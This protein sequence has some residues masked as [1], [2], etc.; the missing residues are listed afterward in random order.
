MPSVPQTFDKNHQE[1]LRSSMPPDTDSMLIKTITAPSAR[2]PNNTKESQPNQTVMPS[3]TM[4]PEK[5]FMGFPIPDPSSAVRI[6]CPVKEDNVPG[7]GFIILAKLDNQLSY[8]SKIYLLDLIKGIKVLLLDEYNLTD[9]WQG[10]YAVSPDRKW[11]AY[12]V[13]L[14][15][16]QNDK[17]NL[18]S[19]VDQEIISLQWDNSWG[20][21][22][23]WLDKEQLIL[24]PTP[25]KI[26]E[27]GSIILM[28]PFVGE[29]KKVA[30][31]F[32]NGIN[33]NVQLIPLAYYNPALTRV[34][35]ISGQYFFLENL[36][37]QQNIWQ[38]SGANFTVKP[39]WSPDGTHFAMVITTK[40]SEKNVI[41]NDLYLVNSDG[42]EIQLTDIGL[43]YPS[44][45]EVYVESFEWSPDGQKI[46]FQLFLSGNGQEIGP[47]LA[48]VDLATKAVDIYCINISRD[49][50]RIIWSP[51]SDQLIITSNVEFVDKSGSDPDKTKDQKKVVLI[52]IVN[53]KISQI[54]ENEI[55]IGWI[56]P[57]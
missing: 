29:I 18:V 54:A 8:E 14:N 17:L 32:P 10:G 33:F 13:T 49:D 24:L 41:H 22:I 28:N 50:G 23:S 47:N 36:Q 43:A 45:K 12:R 5:V 27:Y 52:D 6:Q 26:D 53:E 42:Q 1:I 37:T 20:K 30:P 2:F 48:I 39:S 34:I 4:V 46:A 31:T 7:E 55:P 38:R 25:Q 21:I 51:N 11:F 44:Y 56:A 16:R 40:D 35:Y 15:D 3:E 9:F 19:S 57:P